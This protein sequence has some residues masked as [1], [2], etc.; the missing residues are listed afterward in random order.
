[1][2]QSTWNRTI[3]WCTVDWVTEHSGR[4]DVRGADGVELAV[5]VGGHG[6]ALVMVHGSIADHTTFDSFVA[7]LREHFTTYAMDRRGFGASTDALGYTIDRD[8]ADVAAVVDAVALRTSGP[9]E[10]WGHSYGANCA[11]GGAT[12]SESVNHLILYEPSLGLPYPPGS[13]RRIEEALDR[14]DNDAAIVA[15]L[16]DI[17]EMDDEDID[18]FPDNQSGRCAWRPPT[19]SLA[20]AMPRRIG[21]SPLVS[22]T[23]LRRQPCC[24]AEPR[25]CRSSWTPRSGPRE[26]SLARDPQ[27]RRTRSLRPSHRSQDGAQP[28]PRV[29]RPMRSPILTRAGFDDPGC[30]GTLGPRRR[31]LRIVSTHSTP[32]RRKR[33]VQIAKGSQNLFLGGRVER[34]DWYVVDGPDRCPQLLD[35]FLTAAAQSEM[36]LDPG[37]QVCVQGAS[38]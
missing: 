7:V 10:L 38:R 4:L 11:M 25:A 5:W 24:S 28:D 31:A 2:G 29:R 21:F 12:Q 32:F 34:C 26:R 6:P 27:T 30:T 15:V 8:F 3:R 18:A 19:P 23:R 37:G 1:M 17:L 16:R 20:N 35:I 36:C 9:V 13:I 14:G 22:S 33:T